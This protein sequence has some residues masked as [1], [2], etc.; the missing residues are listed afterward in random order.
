MT[1]PETLVEKAE[2]AYQA[3]DADRIMALFD[4]EVVVYWNGKR[5]WETAAEV[6]EAHAEAIA[7]LPEFEIQKSLR[8]ASGDTITVEWTDRWVD[9]DGTRGEG[10][11][12]E[13]WTMRDDRLREWHVYYETYEGEPT[14]ER[15][16]AYLTVQPTGER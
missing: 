1:D 13:F 11:G 12:A 15:E 16:A 7:A 5:L 3:Q 2:A 8:A 4:P 9:A 10:F 14:D 6:R